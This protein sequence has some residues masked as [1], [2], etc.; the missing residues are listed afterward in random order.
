MVRSDTLN[1]GNIMITDTSMISDTLNEGNIM[2]IMI[3]DPVTV[4]S[5]I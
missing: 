4:I 1:E 2:I 5:Y 3:T